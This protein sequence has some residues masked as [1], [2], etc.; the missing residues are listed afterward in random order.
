MSDNLTR[1]D[2]SQAGA[3]RETIGL[4]DSSDVP[5]VPEPVP[6]IHLPEDLR[7]PWGWGDLILFT[8]VF[9]FAI[10]ASGLLIG[11]GLALVAHSRGANPQELFQQANVQVLVLALQQGMLF[12]LLF[13]YLFARIR[14]FAEKPFWHTIGWRPV[15]PPGSSQLAAYVLSALTG[16]VLA[17][18]MQFA[19]LLFKPESPPPIE[20]FFRT[21][22]SIFIMM[23]LAV[24]LAPVFEETV[25]RGFLYPVL[26]RTLGVPV[27]ILLTGTLFGLMHAVQLWGA[28]W[29]LGLLI[30]VGIVF[31]TIRARTGSV[32]PAYFAHLGYNSALFAYL[33]AA[34]D[35]FRNLPAPQ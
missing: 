9:V 2:N 8:A 1:Q 28:W 16:A 10:L 11:A 27:G 14:I 33:F 24:V 18:G 5:T 32:T 30:V 7:V 22:E 19:S 13:G 17:T 29:Q 34:T 25:F 26:A 21:R 12:A 35:G 15:P 31:T 6:V 4:H 23:G 20:Q 3:A